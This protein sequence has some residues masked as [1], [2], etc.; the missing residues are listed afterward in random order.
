MC[1]QIELDGDDKTS[2]YCELYEGEM[3]DNWCCGEEIENF[4]FAE[5]SQHDLK[6]KC[7][8]YLGNEGPVDEEK[9]KVEGCP[10]DLCLYKKWNICK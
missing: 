6:V 1:F 2:D 10:F 3:N 9:F 5:E 8:D 4:Y 7:I